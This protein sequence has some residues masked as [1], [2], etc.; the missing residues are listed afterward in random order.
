MWWRP[1][2]WTL[3]LCLALAA[4]ARAREED[5][6]NKKLTEEFDEID[7]KLRTLRRLEKT[8]RNITRHLTKL[9]D[10][11]RD[12][13]TRL[14]RLERQMKSLEDVL[15]ALRK[16]IAEV[17]ARSK[18]GEPA[19]SAAGTPSVQ[20]AERAVAA[21]RTQRRAINGDFLII[22]GTVANVS[23]RVLTFVVV[24][25]AFLDA[26]DH[27]VKTASGY[28]TP[29]VIA[30]GGT[31]SFKIIIRRDLRIRNYRLTVRTK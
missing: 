11:F 26:R 21:I 28:T 25:A 6:T 23:G 22:T 13:R 19:K 24:E 3:L 8:D 30:A 18:T 15:V 5:W 20:P 29:R 27:V 17:A 2:R 4:A 9:D 16:E 14:A 10:Q 31:A 12:L 1:T 7:K